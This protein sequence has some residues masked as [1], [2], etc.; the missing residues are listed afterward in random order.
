ML[1]VEGV[2]VNLIVLYFVVFNDS[3]GGFALGLF[4]RLHPLL[5]ALFALLSLVTLLVLILR[6]TGGLSNKHVQ[7]LLL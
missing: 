3:L 6:I 4:G 7:F 5:L 1:V 2:V